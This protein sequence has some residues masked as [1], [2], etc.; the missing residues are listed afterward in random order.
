MLEA[1][2]S[3]PTRSALTRSLPSEATVPA[4]TGSPAAFG[5]A[6]LSR[7][8]LLVDA[9]LARDTV[10][11]TGNVLARVDDHLLAD[12][13]LFDL[14]ANRLAVAHDPGVDVLA[15]IHPLDRAERRRIV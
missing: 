1:M 7:E 13:D 6:G 12:L 2:V 11:S 9:R 14:D 5:R 15:V 4:K 10:P 3:S 8:H